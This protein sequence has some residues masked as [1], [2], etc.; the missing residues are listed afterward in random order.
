MPHTSAPDHERRVLRFDGAHNFRDLGGYA[1]GDGRPIRWGRLY[2]ADGLHRLSA[3]DL[4]RIRELGVRTVIDLRSEGEIVERGGF[5]PDFRG[6]RVH[7][8]PV[9]DATW[10]S[11]PRP[12]FA[13]TDDPATAFLVWAYRQMIDDAGPRFAAAIEL[14]A[15][16]ASLPA[17]FHCAAGKDRTGLLAALVLGVLGVDDEVIAADYQL[18][19]PAMARRY[20]WAKVHAPELADRYDNTPAEMLAARPAAMLQ[21][22][23]DLRQRFGGPAGYLARHGV[24]TSTIDA[25]V[26]ALVGS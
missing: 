11:S 12:S 8:Q 4:E 19:E 20:E 24:P 21:V 22:L 10:T 25:L 23:A 15:R 1:A 26:D 5:P 16:P 7:H 17:V 3:A 13:G 14:L 9:L 18:T 6:V 2:R